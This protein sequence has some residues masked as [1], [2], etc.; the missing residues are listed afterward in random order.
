MRRRGSVSTRLHSWHIVPPHRCT[1]EVARLHPAALPPARVGSA[2]QRPASSGHV[3]RLLVLLA[4]LLTVLRVTFLLSCR[5]R[6]ASV[7][8]F[9]RNV[10]L[11]HWA[12]TFRLCFYPVVSWLK[13][14]PGVPQVEQVGESACVHNK[15][16]FCSP[17]VSV[18]AACSLSHSD[19]AAGTARI[20]LVPLRCWLHQRRAPLC[21]S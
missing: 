20:I 8:G 11:H 10:S 17:C 5:T 21:T 3:Q 19:E 15:A 9:I 14:F 12:F 4:F 18:D 6:A 2:H 1:H 13:R 7:P 16:T